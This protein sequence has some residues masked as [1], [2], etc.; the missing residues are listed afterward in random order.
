LVAERLSS[1]DLSFLCL[2]GPDT[3]MHLG[4]VLIFRPSAGETNGGQ[5]LSDALRRRVTA[6]PRLRRRLAPVG[7][8]LGGAAW[9]EDP[10]FDPAVHVQLWSLQAPGGR[11]ELAARIAELMAVPLERS[12]PLWEL[13]VLDGLGDG[14]VA[15]LAKIHHALADGLRAIGLGFAL[16]DDPRDPSRHDRPIPDQTPMGPTQADGVG[17]A[18][19][20]AVGDLLVS[21]SLLVDPRTGPAELARHAGQALTA[22]GIA[23]SLL[24]TLLHPAPATP[25]NLTIG[26]ARRFEMLRA[27][28]EDVQVVRK[29]HGGTVNDVLLTVIAGGLRTWLATRRH[30]LD[31]PLRVL[32]PVS[33]PPRGPGDAAGNLLSGYLIDLPTD[34]PDPLER[35]RAIRRAMT[36]NKTAGPARGPGAFPVLADLLPS[37]VPRLAASRAAPLAS[38]LFNTV[39]TSVPLPDLPLTLDGVELAEIYPVVPLAAGQALGVAISTYQR[40]VHIGLHADHAAIPDLDLL[41]HYVA[42]ALRELLAL[43]AQVSRIYPPSGP[44]DATSTCE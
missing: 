18:L 8:P 28:L 32:V 10:A 24:Q 35:L 1:L 37:L 15:L 9:V 39:I 13:H 12:R 30:R 42:T 7:F 31:S 3:P 21:A 22:T 14:T 17:R 19:A 23:A 20:G 27:D 34:E 40:T 5:R 29:T 33:R 16:F 44:S 6:V 36:V 43:P 4:A 25:L 38:R 26:P 41:G 11:E 2:E